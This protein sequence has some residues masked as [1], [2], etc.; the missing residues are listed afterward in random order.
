[1]RVRA[2]NPNGDMQFGQSKNNFLVNSP[3]AVAQIVGTRLK[4]WTGEWFLDQQEGTPYLS[5]VLGTNTQ[6]LYDA[7]LTERMLTTPG[8]VGLIDYQSQRDGATRVL[9]VSA[10]LNTQ[11]GEAL[12]GGEQSG[13]VLNAIHDDYGSGGIVSD[14]GSNTPIRF[15]V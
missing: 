15:D 7:A 2:M 5:Q 8:V 3:A 10:R 12:L 13:L 14:D 1:M 11:F 6:S 4:L 9:S